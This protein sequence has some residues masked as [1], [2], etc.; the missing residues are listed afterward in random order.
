MSRVPVSFSVDANF[1]NAS[2]YLPLRMLS[3]GKEVSCQNVPSSHCYHFQSNVQFAT[4]LYFMFILSFSHFVFI[5]S[6]S[7]FR[8]SNLCA[9]VR[10]HQ[11]RGNQ[12]CPSNQPIIWQI[13]CKSLISLM[14]FKPTNSLAH[15]L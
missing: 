5:L 2:I 9:C 1:H 6:D 8:G 7:H 11:R 15:F 13:I 3:H 14:S 12:Q 4:L 10:Y